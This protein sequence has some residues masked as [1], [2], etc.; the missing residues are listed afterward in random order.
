MSQL[1]SKEISPSRYL[2]MPFGTTFTA[3]GITF[4][5]W[6]P[7]ARQV[8]LCLYATGEPR[9]VA[10][11]AGKD[12]WFQFTTSRVRPGDLY[13]FRIDGDLKVPDPA[14][15][16]QPRDVHGPSEIID[17]REF[18]WSDKK[19]VG[20]PWHEAVIYEMHVGTFTPPGTFAAAT[21]KLEHLRDLG[22][23]AIELMPVA[24]FPGTRNWGYDGVL[25]FAPDSSYGRP[26]DL[27]RFVQR[28]HELG[29]MVFMDVVYNH[30]GPE[31]NYL[32]VYGKSFFTDKHKTPWG[33][34]INFDDTH[35]ELVR[36]F[37][38]HNALYWLTE[39]NFDGLRFDAV[40]AI[41]DS[42]ERQFLHQ[43]AAE[44][45]QKLPST[46]HIHLIL[47]NDNN[48]GSLLRRAD[49]APSLFTSQW[50]DDFHHSLHS[51]ATGETTG[52]Y[53]DYVSDTSFAASIEHLGRVLSQGFSYQGQESPH[54]DGVTRG[55]PSQDLPMTA[56]VSFLQ[57]HDQ[58]GNRAF[59]D[60]ISKLAPDAALRAAYSI[61][62]LSP[63]IPMLFMGEEW[64]SK[65]PFNFFA[66]FGEELAPKITE[67]RREEFAK[68]P[69][70]ADP[71]TRDNIPDPCSEETFQLSKLNW[72]DLFDKSHDKWLRLITQL[73]E[74][75]STNIVPRLATLGNAGDTC[76]HAVIAD[77][78]LAAEWFLG[79]G[80]RLTMLA[81]FGKDAIEVS[82]GA[83]VPGFAG[84]KESAPSENAVILFD[85]AAKTQNA[86]RWVSTKSKKLDAW[87]VVWLLD[88]VAAP[89]NGNGGGAKKRTKA[90]S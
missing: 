62:L 86:P 29:I 89:T 81:N 19:W 55:E 42:S 54:R 1:S 53:S 76:K 47:E 60:R 38:I 20:R 64:A 26:D 50:N 87:Q 48:A 80:S 32:H 46:R 33:D 67:G 78:A 41:Y 69:E 43:L 88:A 18:D 61:L 40:H 52:Y 2:A 68:F 7:T 31:G 21:E 63:Q 16:F 59:G 4:R 24:D 58:V 11:P 73:I 84:K 44:I 49:S 82:P 39:Y 8:E 74:I 45:R 51:I 15:R 17:P 90:S 37:F 27:K 5:V 12:S 13:Q 79:D 57:N 70:F 22:I 66:D 25:P 77:N 23:T 65:T 34:A 75:R 10:M 71:Q 72:D 30:F 35:N 14:S 9:M 3:D 28:A 36:S 56:F 6:A 85:T 83:L